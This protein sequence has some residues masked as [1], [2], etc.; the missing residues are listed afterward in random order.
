MWEWGV[1]VGGAN[2][3]SKLVDNGILIMLLYL[4]PSD[5]PQIIYVQ[6]YS[7]TGNY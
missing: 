1:K 7:I 5:I 3:N 6:I 4:K 2:L